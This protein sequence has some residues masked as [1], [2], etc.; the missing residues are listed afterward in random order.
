VQL[1]ICRVPFLSNAEKRERVLRAL[2]DWS[3]DVA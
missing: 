2:I 1:E 3:I